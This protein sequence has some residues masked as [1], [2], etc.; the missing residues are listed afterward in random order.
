M[1]S[2]DKLHLEEMLIMCW[3]GESKSSGG[4]YG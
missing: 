2:S 3:S 1:S 4:V